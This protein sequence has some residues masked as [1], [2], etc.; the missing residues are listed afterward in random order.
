[1][2]ALRVLALTGPRYRRAVKYRGILASLSADFMSDVAKN[3]LVSIAG[4]CLIAGTLLVGIPVDTSPSALRFFSAG[5]LTGTA[6]FLITLRWTWF[7]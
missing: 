7:K 1:M 2:L 3:R 6:M 5:V 4:A